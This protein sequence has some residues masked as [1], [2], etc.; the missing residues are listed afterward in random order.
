MPPPVKEKKKILLVDDSEII[1]LYFRD[2][3]WIHGLDSKYDLNICGDVEKAKQIVKDPL[4]RP[5]L[6]F[7]GLVMPIKQGNKTVSSPEA[8]FSFLSELKSDPELKKIHVIIFS[9]YD[10]KKY[11]DRAKELGADSFLAK[12]ENMPRELVQFIENLNIK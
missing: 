5:S 3:F 12:Q 4:T 1:R 7:S 6:V 9:A 11:Q 10:D 8:G 2:I